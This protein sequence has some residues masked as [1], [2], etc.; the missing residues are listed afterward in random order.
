[1]DERDELM[2]KI[3]LDELRLKIA[4]KKFTKIRKYE[5]RWT[6]QHDTEEW[7]ETRDN[8]PNWPRDIAAAW[9]LVE[10]MRRAGYPVALMAIPE[11]YERHNM[12]EA[13]VYRKDCAKSLVYE[14]GASPAEAICNAYISWREAVQQEAAGEK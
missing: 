4:L 7:G 9:E 1:M 14:Y 11:E 8:I 3:E 2:L 13:K 6:G 12:H 5:D 10:E